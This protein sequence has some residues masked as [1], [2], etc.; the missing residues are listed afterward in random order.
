MASTS[1]H[2]DPGVNR[3]WAQ[4]R[5][6]VD[7]DS[8]ADRFDQMEAA[9]QH[10]H[11]EADA[12][13]RLLPAGASVLDAG[14]GMGR[15]AIE[16]DER[17]FD[18]VGTDIDPDMLAFARSRRPSLRWELADVSTVDLGRSFDLVLLAGNVMLFV[19]EGTEAAVVA[20]MARHTKPGG[21]LVAGFALDGRPTAGIGLSEYDGFC[22]DAGLELVERWATWDGDR[23]P[24]A[25]PDYA[26]SIHRPPPSAK[27]P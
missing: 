26:V 2:T 4:W 9:G 24:A 5:R 3:R 27:S 6:D 25:S 12:I 1:D 23:L 18:V 8:Y 19:P 16:L 13:A 14:C 22:A 15:V 7:L 21:R 20:N 11:G 10:A 17:G